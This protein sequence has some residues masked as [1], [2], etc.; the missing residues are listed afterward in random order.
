MTAMRGE[1][2]RIE[3]NTSQDSK[4]RKENEGSKDAALRKSRKG[5]TARTRKSRGTRIGAVPRRAMA[6]K[7]I[8]GRHV[9]RTGGRKK[10]QRAEKKEKTGNAAT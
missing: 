7:E 2:K 9:P 4:S 6:E 5:R 3:A 8:Q 1:K 10:G